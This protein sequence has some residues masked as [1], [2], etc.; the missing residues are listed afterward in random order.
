LPLPEGPASPT[1][2]TASRFDAGVIMTNSLAER[3]L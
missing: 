3:F 1:T 2:K